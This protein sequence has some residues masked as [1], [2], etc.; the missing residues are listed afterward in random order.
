MVVA[1]TCWKGAEMMEV[2]KYSNFQSEAAPVQG[3]DSRSSC[4]PA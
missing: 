2:M 3:D 4:G 1:K